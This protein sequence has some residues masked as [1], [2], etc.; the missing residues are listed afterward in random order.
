MSDTF[1]EE[2]ERRIV[3]AEQAML[4]RRLALSQNRF[5]PRIA[6]TLVPWDESE[7]RAAVQT[8]GSPLD[9]HSVI[10]LPRSVIFWAGAPTWAQ[11]AYL[12]MVE[13]RAINI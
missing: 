9:V 11:Y 10:G 8:P 6:W 5:Q 1:K 12:L 2:E 7:L 13:V 4:R 3:I